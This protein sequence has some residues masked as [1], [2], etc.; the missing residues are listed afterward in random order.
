MRH[1]RQQIRFS[2]ASCDETIVHLSLTTN[3]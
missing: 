2:C 1:Y 3:G